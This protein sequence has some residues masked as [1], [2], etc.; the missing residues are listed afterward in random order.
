MAPSEYH[1]ETCVY[2]PF[3]DSAHSRARDGVHTTQTCVFCTSG[4]VRVGTNTPRTF[5]PLLLYSRVPSRQTLTLG[6]KRRLL[7]RDSV[8]LI[9]KGQ[10][11]GN[12]HNRVTGTIVLHVP[13]AMFSRKLCLRMRGLIARGGKSGHSIGLSHRG[14]P[15]TFAGPRACLRGTTVFG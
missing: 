2:S 3:D 4:G 6:F 15:V 5:V 9:Y 8:V 7:R 12:V 13:V 1:G 10:L 14:F 11:D